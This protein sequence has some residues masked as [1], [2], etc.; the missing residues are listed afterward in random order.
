IVLPPQTHNLPQNFTPSKKILWEYNTDIFDRS[1]A[2]QMGRHFLSML[3]ELTGDRLRKISEIPWVSD[4]ERQ[5]LL[6]EWNNT[7]TE[8]PRE[9]CV[10]QLFEEHVQKTPTALAVVR[11]EERLSYLEL[12]RRANR[13]ARE[14]KASGVE[15]ESVVAV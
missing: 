9:K 2:E 7:A 15:A 10:H 8:L 6:H 11:G 13:L 12:D 5:H 1:I 4:A 3:G 14:L